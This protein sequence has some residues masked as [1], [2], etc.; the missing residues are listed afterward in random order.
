M[1]PDSIDRELLIEAVT[2]LLYGTTRSLVEAILERDRERA[3]RLVDTAIAT[4][5]ASKKDAGKL[6]RE[7]CRMVPDLVRQFEC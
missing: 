1:N 3:I 5:E 4:L 2:A 7:L 6:S